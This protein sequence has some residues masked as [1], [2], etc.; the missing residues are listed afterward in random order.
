MQYKRCQ[1]ECVQNIP[2][3]CGALNIGWQRLHRL[4]RIIKRRWRYLVNFFRE[5]EHVKGRAQRSA[6]SQ[7]IFALESGDP[8]RVRS[9]NEIQATLDRWNQLRGC[10]FMEEMWRHCG[11]TQ[12]VH[13]R[14]ERF[15]DERDYLVKRCKGMTSVLVTA[16]ASISGERNGWRDWR[17]RDFPAFQ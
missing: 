3:P 16:R 12:R 6:A 9:R 14:V 13:K 17:N 2:E 7:S 5:S 8:V 4:K 15:M 11:T 1:L 10:A